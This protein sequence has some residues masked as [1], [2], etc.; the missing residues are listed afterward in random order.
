MTSN[1]NNESTKGSSN[2]ANSTTANGTV[3]TTKKKKTGTQTRI[4]FWASECKYSVILD[5]VSE[6]DWKLVE[7]ER[8]QNRINLFWID[9][10]T[11][12]EHFKHIQPWQMI[13]H[14]PVK[15][16]RMYLFHDGL[17][18]MCTEEYVKP[19]KHNL[20]VS[21]MHLTNYAVNKHNENF[22]Q[23]AAH[24]SE[25]YQTQEDA[26]K[27]SLLWFMNWVKTQYGEQK[28]N[29]LWKRMGVLCTRT[30]LAIL[31]TL[32]REYDQHFKS[33]NNI[34]VDI[35]KI[36]TST[37]SS[38][39]NVSGATP[40]PVKPPSSMKS[41]NYSGR[42]RA[43]S[44]DRAESVGS[45]DNDDDDNYSTHRNN[46]A[47]HDEEKGTNE[48]KASGDKDSDYPKIR[49]SRCFEVLG[50]DIM[51]DS[52][53][54]P[55]LIEVNHLP[56]FGTDSPLDK[57]IKDRLMRQVFSV[58]PTMA[59]DQAAYAAYHKAESERRLNAHKL[60]KEQELKALKEKPKLFKAP[61]YR[62]R[63]SS[64]EKSGR[65]G[66]NNNNNE[67][68]NN[69]ASQSED[70]QRENSHDEQEN[71]EQEEEQE[72]QQTVNEGSITGEDQNTVSNTNSNDGGN[73]YNTLEEM[74]ELMDEECTPE[75]IDEIK[76][77]LI[78]IYQKKS[79][80]KINKIERLLAKYAG[81]EEEFLLFV[82][83]KYGISPLEY[84][85]S[86]PKKIREVLA[87]KA[88]AAAAAAASSSTNNDQNAND[89]LRSPDTIAT[90]SVKPKNNNN[91]GHHGSNNNKS[92]PKRYSRS[93]SPPRTS[94]PRR[95]A[96]AWKSSISDED[97][98]LKTEILSTHIPNE[99]DEWMKL[100]CRLLTQ[101][102][103][104]FP[105]EP[106][107]NDGKAGEDEGE[108]GGKEEEETDD[109]DNEGQQEQ[110]M[111]KEGSGGSAMTAT[112]TATVK[113]KTASYE[114]I[115]FKVFLED[116]RMMYRKFRPLPHR[117]KTEEGSAGSSGSFLPPLDPPASSR[118][119]FSSMGTGKGVVGWKA[120]PKP[121]KYEAPKQ[122]T[123]SQQDAAKRL[124][125]G[126]SVAS[127][128][129]QR[130]A[131]QAAVSLLQNN[132]TQYSVVLDPQEMNNNNNNNIPYNNGGAPYV[133]WPSTKAHRLYEESRSNRMKIEQARA[134]NAAVLR[135]QIFFFDPAHEMLDNASLSGSVTG[136]PGI[137]IGM[138][139]MAGDASSVAFY[140]QQAPQR[141][142][143]PNGSLH[144]SSFV[145]VGGG[146]GVVQLTPQQQAQAL[147]QQQLRAR[148]PTQA[149]ASTAQLHQQ[150]QPPQPV[151]TNL[152]GVP[153]PLQ[154]SVG[155]AGM[156]SGMNPNLINPAQMRVPPGNNM[157]NGGAGLT[158]AVN[159]KQEELL[160]QLFPSWF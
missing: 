133:L 134:H 13:N 108:F 63:D 154:Q 59:D 42:I 39:A 151:Y 95:V 3:T 32:S 41:N 25:D 70:E 85:N 17:V 10:A 55:W 115:I 62:K 82:F 26:S 23:P 149:A 33:F 52:N 48:E 67:S 135:Q 106:K 77:I 15:P 120:P 137:G 27:R 29:W 139:M 90:D 140:G 113:S 78:D 66:S 126:L 152:N 117:V 58:V 45:E 130:N 72:D 89:G 100:E 160:R 57:D 81:H 9:V 16:L 18:R 4:Y 91:N 49:G 24:S 36:P 73:N 7:D 159:N 88:A 53:L 44:R 147:Q 87:A 21:C 104:I 128:V 105:P 2:P 6:L 112:T 132:E 74:M 46:N 30:I 114:D 93:L 156:T 143:P 150:G 118:S 8:L 84:E 96:P 47:N 103:R 34:P 99:N 124:S 157:N 79:P 141:Q 38:T 155:V 19:T 102:T 43:S 127:T 64:L 98:V 144:E 68:N 1:G 61:E 97:A 40:P 94:G 60:A 80:E 123:P 86:K 20:G 56:S 31:P 116:R 121:V 138:G 71:E 107:A 12:H 122:P 50:F 146:V 11:I 69:T 145:S 5:L 75:R 131:T 109:N 158:N 148:L 14:F 136:G 153:I 37:N 65:T 92:D 142:G 111:K 76:E 125:Q 110:K 119:S 54:S 83:S 101:C 129:R 28:A 51:V 35:T 22:T